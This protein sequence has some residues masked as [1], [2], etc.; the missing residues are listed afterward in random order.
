VLAQSEKRRQRSSEVL[1]TL[2]K[3]KQRKRMYSKVPP[4]YPISEDYATT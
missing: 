2:P 3:G 4:K 1:Q